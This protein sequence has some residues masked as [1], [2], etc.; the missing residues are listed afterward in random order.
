MYDPPPE[1]GDYKPVF[2]FANVNIIN[3]STRT[4]PPKKKK[5]NK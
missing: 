5:N 2:L 4:P 1:N 3:R